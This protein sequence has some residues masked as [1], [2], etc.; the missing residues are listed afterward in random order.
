M[1]AGNRL[2][3]HGQVKSGLTAER[4]QNRVGALLFDDA[5]DDFRCETELA[6]AGVLERYGVEM[7]GA[8]GST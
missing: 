3:R 8:N 2:A 1:I 6:H 4:C 5:L 7:I